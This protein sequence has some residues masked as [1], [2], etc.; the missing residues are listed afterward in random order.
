MENL[1][2]LDTSLL[3]DLLSQ[4]TERYTNMLT[5]GCDQEE[6]EKCKLTIEAIQKEIQVRQQQLEGNSAA[7]AAEPDFA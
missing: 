2:S 1:N 4:Y 5:E 3:V 7:S 6:F